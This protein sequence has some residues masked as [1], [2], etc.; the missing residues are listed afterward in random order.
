MDNVYTI[1]KFK[2]EVKEIV[3]DIDKEIVKY[4]QSPKRFEAAMAL[5]CFVVAKKQGKSPQSVAEEL[6]KK[7]RKKIKK[8]SLVADVKASGPYVNFFINYKTFTGCVLNEIIERNEKYG[9]LPDKK[10]KIMIEFSNP[11]PCKAMHIGHARTTFLGDSLARIM[12]FAGYDVIRANYYNDMGKQ[13]AKEVLAYSMW[14]KGGPTKKPD[15]WLADLYV[16]LHKEGDEVIKKADEI[17][18]EIEMNK[19]KK[20]IEI[21]KKVVGLA[22]KGFNETYKRLGISF[23]VEIRE[24]EHRPRGK[25]LVQQALKMGVAFKSN[26]GT[27]V[28][29]LEKYGMPSCVILR[30]DGTGVY[31][32]SDLGTTEYKFKKFGLDKS[33]WVVGEDQKLYFKQLFKILELLGYKWAKNCI[34]LSYGMVTLKGKKMSSR[35]GAFITIDEIMDELKELAKKEIEKKNP[36]LKDKDEVAEKIGIGAF[37]Y[38]ILRIEPNHVVDFNPEAVTRFE[39]D[40]GPYL[41]YTH[42]RAS[43]IL[44]KAEKEIK[45]KNVK[46]IYLES[47]KEKE[48]IKKLSEFPE[49]VNKSSEELK[50]HQIA[51]YLL[52]L[53]SLFNEYY[54]ST[55]VIGSEKEQERL[56]LVEAVRIVLRNG[57]NL[58][59]I[60]APEEM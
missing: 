29:D 19:N 48:I 36:S 23:D 7:I 12:S 10:E 53:S 17:L 3:S 15:Q 11:N 52:E 8:S 32:T 49:V 30:S 54:H 50:P 31:Y 27:V 46:N 4:I 47:E 41:Q 44:R 42:A 56:V 43:S 40:T 6:A 38:A 1:E 26:E 9:E 60:D 33:I 55:K 39:G 51:G 24:S 34:H 14:G 28:A 37:K 5:P 45:S 21:Q 35:K 22:L 25:E 2:K 59:G 13:V 18:F 58:L 16:K 20:W 57:L